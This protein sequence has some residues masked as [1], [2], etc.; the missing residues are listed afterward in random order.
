MERKI[1]VRLLFPSFF[2]LPVKKLPSKETAR[3]IEF[4]IPND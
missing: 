3:H 4:S 2:T 1:H